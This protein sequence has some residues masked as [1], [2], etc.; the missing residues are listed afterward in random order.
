MIVVV[1]GIDGAGKTTLC[2]NL[3]AR[4]GFPVYKP[5]GAP[6]T[7]G[8]STLESQGHDRG[9]IGVLSALG[10]ADLIMDRSF[11][12]EFVYS[13]VFQRQYDEGTVFAL[14]ALVSQMEHL[15]VICT[16]RA[17]TMGYRLA[18]RRGVQDLTESEWCTAWSLYEEYMDS[19]LMSY[20]KC[21]GE[22]TLIDNVDGVLAAIKEGPYVRKQR[23]ALR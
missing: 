14:D 22:D 19:T 21:F 15:L 4:L 17:P 12:S 1:E 13:S 5:I 18:K 16:F 9:A 20:F 10:G 8:M 6:L 3:E 2:A 11:P 23:S 7:T